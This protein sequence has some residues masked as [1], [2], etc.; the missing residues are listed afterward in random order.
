MS[1]GSSS[2]RAFRRQ[3]VAQ[4]LLVVLEVLRELLL[5]VVEGHVVLVDRHLRRVGAARPSARTATSCSSACGT[6]A[7]RTLRVVRPVTEPATSAAGA[8]LLAIRDRTRVRSRSSSCRA[9]ALAA[10]PLRRGSR[11]LPP[12]RHRLELLLGDRERVVRLREPRLEVVVVLEHLV[13]GVVLDLARDVL[14]VQVGV[15]RRIGGVLG[16]HA[17]VEEVDGLLDRLRLGHVG[18]VALA[19]ALLEEALPLALALVAPR[20]RG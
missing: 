14:L 5:V 11:V 7:Q 6:A 13:E 8:L 19:R 20:S 18:V 2:G 17:V 3:Q 16:D 9:F 1:L 10:T 4:G 15:V 12:E